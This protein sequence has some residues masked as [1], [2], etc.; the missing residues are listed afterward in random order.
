MSLWTITWEPTKSP[1]PYWAA[2]RNDSFNDVQRGWAG[3]SVSGHRCF[4]SVDITDHS[5]GGTSWSVRWAVDVALRDDPED[6]E[7][8]VLSD[9]SEANAMEYAT[10]QAE[11]AICMALMWAARETA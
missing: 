8:W 11:A 4:A 7:G 5:D 10:V 2:V 3:R 1:V 6:V 9:I